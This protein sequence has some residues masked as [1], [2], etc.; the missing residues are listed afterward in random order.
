[1]RYVYNNPLVI[2]IIEAKRNLI[3]TILSQTETINLKTY[4]NFQLIV[5]I[6]ILII[7]LSLRRNLHI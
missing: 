2:A 4:I 3:L 5:Y 1:M 7:V 6:F